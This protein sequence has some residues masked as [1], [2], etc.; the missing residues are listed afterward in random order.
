VSNCLTPARILAA[1]D[2]LPLGAT[3]YVPGAFCTPEIPVETPVPVYP[4]WLALRPQA[5]VLREHLEPLS[6]LQAD[7]HRL[8]CYPQGDGFRVF[9]E[10]HPYYWA[11][12]QT[13]ATALRELSRTLASFGLSYSQYTQFRFVEC[14]G[15]FV[16]E[17]LEWVSPQR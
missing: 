5:Y 12:G 2:Q 15:K 10:A 6:L 1:T 9:P 13:R 4:H 17:P 16:D 8:I 11:A 3:I 14:N 7:P